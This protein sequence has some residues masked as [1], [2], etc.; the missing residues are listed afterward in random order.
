MVVDGWRMGGGWVMNKSWIGGGWVMDG[1]W[2]DSGWVVNWWRMCIGRVV[3][4]W[5]IGGGRVVDAVSS[6]PHIKDSHTNQ[7]PKVR[8]LFRLIRQ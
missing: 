2:T 4:G 7:M 5:R 1:W 3:D 6:T 8:A